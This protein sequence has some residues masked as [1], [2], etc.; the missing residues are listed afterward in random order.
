MLSRYGSLI[1]CFLLLGSAW[2]TPARAQARKPN[3][4]FILTDDMG[5]G[6]I[7]SYGVTDI[8]TPHLD[9]LA[10]EGVR[11]TNNYSNGPVCTPT[12]AAFITGRYQQRV[13]LEWAIPPAMKEPGLPV[14][15]VSVA[16]MLKNNGYATALFGKWHLGYKPEYSPNAH[17]F[18]EFFGIL[19]GNIDHYSHK[20]VNG[21]A[22]LYENTQPVERKGYMTDLITERAVAFITRQGRN[23]FFLYVA[24][25]SVHWPFQ[26]PGRFED[27][28]T[29]PTWHK[30]TRQDYA[31]MVESIDQGVGQILRALDHKGIAKDTL[32]IFTNDNGGE[33]LSRNEPLFHHKGTLWE[34]GIRVPCL[35]RWPDH[36][37][38]GAVSDQPTMTMDLTA[39]LLAAA[40][41]N[42]PAGRTLDGM[43]LLPILQGK[44]TPTTR[45]FF[46]RIDRQDRK[47][48][49][50]RKGQWK[51]IRDGNIEMLFDLQKDIGERLDLAYRHPEMVE[52]LRGLLAQWEKEMDATPPRFSVK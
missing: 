28:R 47:Q 49:A 21:E 26:A 15:E 7:G 12:R 17:G 33:R 45:I 18:D 6:D 24:Y 43:N 31:L 44:Q 8:R 32:V 27:V 1:L 39:T 50:V 46:W 19:S 51:Y 4:I 16:R 14:S 22:D 41:A 42:A 20:E 11:L 9:R 29:R 48:R 2:V 13:G 36:L 10:R 35:L 23:P 52:E 37:P 5:Y 30:G 34:G 38:A 40:G 3:V 25:N